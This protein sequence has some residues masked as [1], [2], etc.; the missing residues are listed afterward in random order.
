MREQL[1]HKYN[2]VIALVQQREIVVPTIKQQAPT[3][4]HILFMLGGVDGNPLANFSYNVTIGKETREGRT[5]SKG[6]VT[7]TIDDTSID[8]ITF[9]WEASPPRERTYY[10]EKND[11]NTDEGQ[12]H[13]IS[14]LFFAKPGLRDLLEKELKRIDEYEVPEMEEYKKAVKQLINLC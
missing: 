13:R 5:S 7:E 10:L 12:S 11:F 3:E 9:E 2:N 8:E 4:I 1:S 6:L 14:N